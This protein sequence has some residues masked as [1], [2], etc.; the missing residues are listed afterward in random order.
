ME[1]LNAMNSMQTPKATRIWPVT[2][3]FMPDFTRPSTKGQPI[4]TSDYHD[5]NHDHSRRSLILVFV[6]A[7]TAEYIADPVRSSSSS[8]LH[9]LARRYTEIVSESA[10]V[11]VV[12]RGTLE[13]AVQLQRYDNLPFPVLADE[14]GQVHRDYG[15]MTRDGRTASQAVFVA[16]R[17]GKI[18]L[19][20]R[21]S[22]GPPLPTVNGIL[23]SLDFIESRC[24]ECGREEL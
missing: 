19:S 13:E 8:L 11:L 15:A 12:V 21:A 5:C 7:R 3:N 16:G 6:G 1:T 10:Q 2:G 23:G 14:D 18:Y 24:P 17:Y 20:S 4:P 22:D 9:D